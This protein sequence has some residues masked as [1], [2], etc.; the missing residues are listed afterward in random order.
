[1]L[2]SS[3]A[4]ARAK[5]SLAALV[6][7]VAPGPGDRAGEQ[8]PVAGRGLAVGAVG[9]VL[10]L[11]LG[12]V[13]EGGAGQQGVG[14]LLVQLQQR[15][16]G[17]PRRE[18]LVG[19]GHRERGDVAP[20]GGQV[21]LD[22]DGAA[23]V[24][25][26]Q[27]LPAERVVDLVGGVDRLVADGVG[28]ASCLVG[29]VG[30]PEG[31]HGRRGLVADP[32]RGGR[33]GGGVVGVV[34]H[35][36]HQRPEV[37][38]AGRE[39][40]EQGPVGG[41]ADRLALV[42]V[43]ALG[44]RA[45]QRPAKAGPDRGRVVGRPGVVHGGVHDGQGA[46]VD[47]G[48]G[49]EGPDGGQGLLAPAQHGVVVGP[50]PVAVERVQRAGADGQGGQGEPDLDTHL[51]LDVG[52]GVCDHGAEQGHDECE[53]QDESTGH[54]ALPLRCETADQQ[55]RT[56]AT[57]SGH[58]QTCPDRKTNEFR[59]RDLVEPRR[60]GGPGLR[61]SSPPLRP[62]RPRRA[63]PSRGGTRWPSPSGSARSHWSIAD[64]RSLR[65]PAW[66][67]AASSWQGDRGRQGG[68]VGDDPVDQ[69]HGERL[70]GADGPAG[71]Q[72]VQAR[73]WPISRGS[74]IV[75]RSISGTP[76][77]RLKRRGSPPRPPPAGRTRVPARGLRPPPGPRSRPARARSS[78]S[79]VGLIGPS[80]CGELLAAGR[81]RPPSG[82]PRRRR[83]RR[84]RSA[85][86]PRHPGR[87]RSR[88]RSRPA[89]P[90]PARPRRCAARAGR[91]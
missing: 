20:V 29:P 88:G 9:P 66:G 60:R 78:R 49:L 59:T 26:A 24:G 4:L 10:G 17:R 85:R 74:R 12:Q 54:G 81:R 46:G 14:D 51:R 73:A 62:S 65:R 7:A 19:R 1:M 87:G 70:G 53:D 57:T 69:A 33:V 37:G 52:G 34:A 75:P 63:S 83:P 2:A 25:V 42:G 28:V 5:V 36:R 31:E 90:R 18:E 56:I 48:A 68:A 8:Q 47:G 71:E 55:R 86:R 35:P 67:R 77:R 50:R 45:A 11:D 64:S 22:D 58:R 3:S 80:P 79:R 30:G 15:P 41:V 32:G 27:R 44:R 84:R 72:Q 13:G 82:R 43:G 91:S 89:R 61:R 38:R 40:V 6:E 76:K 39:Q 16:L 23:G 21:L